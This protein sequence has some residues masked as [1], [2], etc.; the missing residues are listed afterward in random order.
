[1]NAVT[2]P[3]ALVTVRFPN[4]DDLMPAI[5]TVRQ[6]E[7]IV[8]WSA[9]DGH[10]DLI[11]HCAAPPTRLPDAITAFGEIGEL[12]AFELPYGTSGSV[13]TPGACQ[14]YVFLEIDEQ[15]RTAIHASLHTL[16]GVA[17]SSGVAGSP[18]MVTVISAENFDK[19]DAIVERIRAIDGVLRVKSDRIINLHQM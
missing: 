11:L 15:A 12:H 17:F 10:V 5:E 18:A 2:P 9:V 3:G 16:P 14:A 1:M 19:V 6:T 7:G 4:G 8:C 13:C